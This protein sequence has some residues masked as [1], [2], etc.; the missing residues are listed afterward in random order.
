M[1]ASVYCNLTET[2]IY[3]LTSDLSNSHTR[4]IEDR[5]YSLAFNESVEVKLV[6]YKHSSTVKVPL[7]NILLESLRSFD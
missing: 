7:Q 4:Q 3:R 1:Q 2:A 5:Y 6:L